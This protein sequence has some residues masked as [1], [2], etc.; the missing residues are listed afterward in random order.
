MKQV[1]VVAISTLSDVLLLVQHLVQLC[2]ADCG[3]EHERGRTAREV[4]LRINRRQRK[5]ADW[6][7]RRHLFSL[8]RPA[9]RIFALAQVALKVAGKFRRT[10]KKNLKTGY[11]I[12]PLKLTKRRRTMNT[13]SNN[14]QNRLSV[15]V[16]KHGT[17]KTVNFHP[18]PVRLALLVALTLGMLAAS[19]IPADAAVIQASSG[20]PILCVNVFDD[21]PANETKVIAYPC[22]ADFNNQWDWVDGQFIGLGTTVAG[23]KCLDVVGN[24]TEVGAKI[25]LFSCNGTGGQQWEIKN[26]KNLPGEIYNPASGLCLDLSGGEGAQLTL[27]VCDGSANQNWKIE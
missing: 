5:A 22:S 27:Q 11:K 8:Q 3:D 24:S 16:S 19:R 17:P 2:T 7:G 21:N 6:S 26:P 1:Q 23:S 13:I 10:T 15:C 9:G 25:D 20:L 4:Q 18:Q 14:T 12:S